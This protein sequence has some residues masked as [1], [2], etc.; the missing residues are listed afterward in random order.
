MPPSLDEP[1]AY[2]G[3]DRLRRHGPSGYAD[4]SDYKPWLRDEF[5][6]RCVYCLCRERWFPDGHRSCSID[7]L[8]PRSTAGDTPAGHDGLVYACSICNSF[9]KAALLP[10][11]PSLALAPHLRVHPDGSIQ[12][13]TLVGAAF[14]LHCALDRVDLTAFR[15]LILD[16]LGLLQRK[17]DAAAEAVRRRWL[18]YP[19]DLPD[20]SLLRPPG[21]N[22]RPEGIARSAFARRQRG[23]L[24][25]A[26]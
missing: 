16:T 24:P 22:T 8:L 17:D 2:P 9:R 21:G 10:Q 13:L 3:D 7:H 6:Y 26:Y 12:A 5:D 18:S 14:V 11:D 4:D 25:A 15:K 20:L 1:F 23:E 19:D